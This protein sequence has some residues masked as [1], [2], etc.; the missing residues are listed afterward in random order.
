M[1]SEKVKTDLVEN[2]VNVFSWVFLGWNEIC[3][4]EIEYNWKIER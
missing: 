1:I 3:V 4:Y 2:D